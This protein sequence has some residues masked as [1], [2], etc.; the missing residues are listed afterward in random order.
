LPGKVCGEERR[1]EEA[2]IAH[3]ERFVFVQAC[4]AQSLDLGTEVILE[5]L[6]IDGIGCLPPPDL[7]P[8]PARL[9][10]APDRL[11]VTLAL[12]SVQQWVEHALCPLCIGKPLVVLDVNA[13]PKIC[14]TSTGSS[15]GTLTAADFVNVHLQV[16]K[17]LVT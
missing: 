6:D 8:P 16:C 7:L 14:G 2:E 1:D 10:L 5:F 15:I 3:P 17:I 4:F 11:D 9:R 13:N 12:E